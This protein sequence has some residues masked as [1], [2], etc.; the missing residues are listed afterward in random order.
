GLVRSSASGTKTCGRTSSGRWSGYAKCWQSECQGWSRRGRGD[1]R[2]PLPPACGRRYL[3]PLRGG[4]IRGVHGRWRSLP[5]TPGL[6]P[7]VPSPTS[8]GTDPVSITLPPTPGLRPAVPSPTPF[9][10]G[11]LIGRSEGRLAAHGR[12]AGGDQVLYPVT[13]SGH[14]GLTHALRRDRRIHHD[15]DRA[16]TDP[17]LTGLERL[18]AAVDGQGKDGQTRGN[19][20]REGP[21]LEGPHEA[22]AGAGALGVDDQAPLLGD[23][24][25]R[26]A[27]DLGMD[28]GAGVTI[29]LDDP[30]RPHP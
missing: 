23:E 13:E 19:G 11:G 26:L 29:D 16:A 1:G 27:V 2:Y 10:R 7:A 30:D 28:G 9:G 8:W 18:V 3:P 12:D 4:L 24:I 6:R 21:L 22:V 14:V 15:P 17:G 5:P 20:H 25:L